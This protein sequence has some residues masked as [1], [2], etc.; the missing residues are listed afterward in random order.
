MGLTKTHL[1]GIMGVHDRKWFSVVSTFNLLQTRKEEAMET[2]ALFVEIAKALARERFELWLSGTVKKYQKHT[3]ASSQELR[4]LLLDS[5][6]EVVTEMR[7]E[8]L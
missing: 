2:Q 3:T 4:R 6:S 5:I 7:R 8:L 1:Y